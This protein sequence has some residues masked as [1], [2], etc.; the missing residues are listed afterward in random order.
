MP[1]PFAGTITS[2]FLSQNLA[3]LNLW[4]GTYFSSGTDNRDEWPCRSILIAEIS[5]LMHPDAQVTFVKY[6]D[7]TAG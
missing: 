1:V 7:R 3:H 5:S 6:F 4:S 2:R